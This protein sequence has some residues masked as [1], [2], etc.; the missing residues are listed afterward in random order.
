MV[1]DEIVP[2]LGLFNHFRTRTHDFRPID[3]INEF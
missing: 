2:L 1:G 3:S